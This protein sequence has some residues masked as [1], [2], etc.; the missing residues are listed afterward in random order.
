MTVWVDVGDLLAYGALFRRPSGV[1][2]VVFELCQALAESESGQG[3]I[4]FVRHGGGG[5]ERVEWS[6]ISSVF[7]RLGD[8]AP[9]QDSPFRLQM[10]ALRALLA[11]P[12]SLIPRRHKAS[13][14]GMRK[15][16]VL[17]LAGAGWSDGDHVAQVAAARESFGLTVALLVYDIIPALRPE[18]F[19]RAQSGRFTRWLDG[20]LAI[21]DRLLAISHATARD[22][23]AYRA[24]AGLP[25]CTVHVVRL[26]DGLPGEAREILLGRPYAL[27]VSTLE[28]RK[29][30][31]L[32]VEVWRRLLAEMG[33]ERL[34]VLVFAGRRGGLTGDLMRQLEASNFLGGH[35]VLR[36]DSSDAEL[37]GLYRGCHF[38]LFPSHYEGWGLP[39]AESLAFGKPCLASSASSVPE[40]G[41]DLV[42]YF[43]PLDPEECA[44]LVRSV[45]LDPRGRAAWGA[46]IE[47]E[48]RPVAWSRTAAMVRD[49][50][51]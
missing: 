13:G 49:G 48:Y 45:V 25:D 20:M 26:G 29:N 33:G 47:A 1:Q 3:D 22:V 32:L 30:H 21:S 35:V 17:L 40:V 10:A 2:R 18:W 15:G 44:A 24:A 31:A 46:R 39:V 36:S 9:T 7:N 41:G 50:V 27:F 51:A 23:V 11:V 43:D 6:A 37:A 16:D 34:P 14:T 12:A 8:D 38:T 19:D 28:I 4:G 42:R 5:F